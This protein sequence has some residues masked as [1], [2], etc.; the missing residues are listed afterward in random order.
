M[1]TDKKT[2]CL[3]PPET[4]ASLIPVSRVRIHHA[5]K[6]CLVPISYPKIL[7]NS[8]SCCGDVMAN[9]AGPGGC[10]YSQVSRLSLSMCEPER[11]VSI[12]IS[13]SELRPSGMQGIS[14]SPSLIGSIGSCSAI[15]GGSL[16][17]PDQKKR[18]TL[19][20]LF[21]GSKLYVYAI[22]CRA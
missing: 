20:L 4:V 16:E 22:K 8:Q 19:S 18:K 12:S 9:Q 2:S 10:A 13:R 1:K 3:P 15:E 14:S 5:T 7:Q 6:L 21:L 17:S 11:T